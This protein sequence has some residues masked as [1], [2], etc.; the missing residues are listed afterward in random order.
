MSV[1][2]CVDLTALVNIIN[3]KVIILQFSK[4]HSSKNL[5]NYAS[6]CFTFI[7]VLLLRFKKNNQSA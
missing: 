3:Y 2:L 1:M 4:Q 7:E 6:G 5:E